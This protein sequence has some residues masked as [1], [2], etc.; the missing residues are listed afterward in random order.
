MSKISFRGSEFSVYIHGD[1]IW[2][3][4]SDLCIGIRMDE[5]QLLNKFFLKKFQ[6]WICLQKER[7]EIQSGM[8]HY[9][10]SKPKNEHIKIIKI[11]VIIYED[12]VFDILF[13]EP[14]HGGN[15]SDRIYT[16]RQDSARMIAF[17]YK[18]VQDISEKHYADRPSG[19]SINSTRAELLA[20]TCL[21]QATNISQSINV[22]CRLLELLI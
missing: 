15:A 16:L 7:L 21:S 10:I 17:I 11:P 4:S 19:C 13:Y 14:V 18:L 20:S 6:D 22:L 8:V 12:D 3:R 1:R 5:L 2:I 9:P